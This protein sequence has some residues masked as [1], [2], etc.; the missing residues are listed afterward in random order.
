[1]VN[2]LG[3]RLLEDLGLRRKEGRKRGRKGG[4]KEGLY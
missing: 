1:M 2:G 3:Q 4:K